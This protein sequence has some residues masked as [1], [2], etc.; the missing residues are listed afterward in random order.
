M[1]SVMHRSLPI[2]AIEKRLRNCRNVITLGVRPNFSDYSQHEQALIHK[3]DKIYYPSLFYADLLDAMGKKTFP[4]YHTYKCVQDKIKQTTLFELTGI[5]H[6][7]TRLFYGKKKQNKIKAFFQFPF[8]AKI[9]RGSA[10]GRGVYLIQ[11]QNDLEEYCQ[12]THVAYIQE[13]LPIKKDIR[14]VIIG[15]QAVLAYWRVAPEN[16]FRT[17]ISIGGTVNLDHIPKSAVDLA[18]HTTRVC[19]WDDVGIDIIEHDHHFY[20]I[21]ANMKYGKEGFRTAGIDYTRLMEELIEK[22][23]I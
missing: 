18:L 13:Y 17:N 6:P 7:R 22:G 19:G 2:V 4:S 21:E 3:A 8:I 23:D 12:K 14:V 16:E 10:M 5:P 20:V 9:P 11:D 1:D 15:R